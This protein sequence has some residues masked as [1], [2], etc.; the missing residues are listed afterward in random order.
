MS[1][2]VP[3]FVWKGVLNSELPTYK[4][5]LGSKWTTCNLGIDHIISFH[6]SVVDRKS[7]V[8]S[9]NHQI[10]HSMASSLPCSCNIGNTYCFERT[11]PLTVTCLLTAGLQLVIRDAETAP[12]ELFFELR[13]PPEHGVILKYTAELQGPM[14]AG[15]CF[16][17]HG[18]AW[19]VSCSSFMSQTRRKASPWNERWGETL[20]EQFFSSLSIGWKIW[21]FFLCTHKPKQWGCFLKL[22]VKLVEI[23]W[24]IW[25]KCI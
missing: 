5:T 16:L 13:K 10:A 23:G 8:P 15:N 11:R 3:S 9:Y 14:A 2:S 20:K 25:S 18:P 19:R 1:A 12:E 17:C 22:W 6:S 24:F 21:D 7:T 4:L